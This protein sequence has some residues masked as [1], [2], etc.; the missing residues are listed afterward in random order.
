MKEMF[1]ALLKNLNRVPI[2]EFLEFIQIRG[3]VVSLIQR[4]L[5][6]EE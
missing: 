6:S 3:I 4:N 5:K 2:Y 1:D